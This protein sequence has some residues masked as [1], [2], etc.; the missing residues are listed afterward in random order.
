MAWFGIDICYINNK[1]LVDSQC[2]SCVASD[3]AIEGK[4]MRHSRIT[5]VIAV[6]SCAVLI[7]AQPAIATAQD[8]IPAEQYDRA[9]L[10][11]IG[12]AVGQFQPTIDF[13]ALIRGRGDAAGKGALSGAGTC[14]EL[15]R[16]SASGAAAGAAALVFLA[17]LPIGATIG[18]IS[19]DRRAAPSETIDSAESSLKA[20]L[21]DVNI[22]G[23]M[24]KALMEYAQKNGLRIGALAP[25]LGP[26]SA[27]AAATYS[28]GTSGMDTVLEVSLTKITSRTTG[29]KEL[30]IGFEISVNVRLVQL[31]VNKLLDNFTHIYRGPHRTW[32]EWSAHGG[33]LIDEDFEQGYR[34][35][36]EQVLDEVF[37]IYR[38]T[39]PVATGKESALTFPGE[40]NFAKENT[41][42]RGKVPL[43][44]LRPVYPEVRGKVYFSG[45]SIYGLLE[46]VKVDSIRPALRWEAFPRAHDV[47]L[48]GESISRIS[49][50]T[51]E[52]K[53]YESVLGRL[54]GP[55]ILAGQEIY[56]RPGLTA[57]AHQVEVDLRNCNVYFWTVRARFKLD[58]IYRVTEWMGAYNTMGGE[59][60]PRWWRRSEFPPL[61][62]RFANKMYYLPF[63][64]PAKEGVDCPLN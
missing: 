24:R 9:P 25:E 45:P 35:I 28:T 43:Y 42:I 59:A 54:G 53:I 17:C 18:A 21:A 60:D 29:T 22:Q 30:L 10:G 1:N 38:P 47:P 50:V 11:T 39:A 6:A 34:D 33:K 13:D 56:S 46:R 49:E 3:S 14:F 64:T 5:R 27:D 61:V 57:P 31:S 12:L 52:L 4:L 15:L 41:P 20:R 36:A 2:H 26:V 48:S 16:G 23:N 44:T 55:V 37:L 62:F 19:A 58:G 51:Y 40:E 63:Q 32:E 8:K 7:F